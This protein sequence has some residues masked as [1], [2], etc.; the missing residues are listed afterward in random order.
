MQQPDN[1]KLIGII[2]GV[3]PYAG[4]DLTQKLFAHTLATR[5]QHHL[6]VILSS[7]PA[8]I[9]DRTAYLSQPQSI[10]NPGMALGKIG[11]EL[12]RA[13]AVVLGIPCNTAHAPS[14]FS[15]VKAQLQSFG[16]HCELVNMIEATF[17]NILAAHP[18]I[19]TLGLLATKGTH[20]AQVYEQT[21]QAFGLNIISP[22]SA[23]KDA[24]HAAI[25]DTRYGIKAV[26]PVTEQATSVLK[27]TAGTLINNGAEAIIMGCTE[28]PLAMATS[29]LSVPKIDPTE[30][31]ARTLITRAAPHKLKPL[32]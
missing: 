14:I 7:Q 24:V 10:A 3:G 23:E 6:A 31:L 2:G 9:S 19:K 26:S 22:S 27:T 17:K 29:S 30:V 18:Q 21:A 5:D 13:G 28:I 12:C 20:A 1:E 32:A 8:R 15:V 25:Y 11:I 16:E 4:L